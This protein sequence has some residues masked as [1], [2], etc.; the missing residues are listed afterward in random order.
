[1]I[2]YSKT[3]DGFGIAYEILG[4]GDLVHLFLPEFG[5]SLEGL[6]D[7]PA[8]TR[9][10]RFLL[11]LGRSICLDRRGLGSSDPVPHERLSRLEDYVTD[12]L[13][14]LD[15]AGAERVVITG[16]GSSGGAAMLFAAT[17]PE[18]TLRLTLANS[19]ARGTRA[20]DY[21][22]GFTAEE[23]DGLATH[24]G[25]NWGTGAITAQ[26][27]P[28]L[29]GDATLIEICARRERLAASPATAEA[30]VRAMA[31][32]DVRQVLPKIN[33]PTLVYFTGDLMHTPVEHSRYLAEHIPNAIL[34]EAPGRTFYVPDEAGGL[35]EWA[36][37]VVGGVAPVTG[38]RKLATVLFTDIVSS[39]DRA[40]ALGDES[41]AQLLEDVDS[42]VAREVEKSDGRIV[43]QTG[44]GHLAIFDGP[45]QAVRAAVAIAR[46]G[47]ALGV[48]MRCGLHV[49]ELEL[50]PNGDV[51]G[52]AVH[53]A[54][55]VMDRAGPREV[56]LSRTVAD[57]AAGAGFRFEER[58]SHELKGVPGTWQLYEV[59]S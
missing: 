21:P 35:D 13:A 18:R 38:D 40:A 16:E 4:E 9:F 14:V 48:D 59:V 1:M 27:A 51:G 46:G 29:G 11:S 6:W 32:A 24:I 39:T 43:K 30:M 3:T 12:M 28:A 47:P 41:W 33:V 36:T 50:R 15:E 49:G 17:H 37:F 44:D 23:M 52:I 58:G 57:L 31:A 10:K 19:S 54:A 22:M 5:S 8:H 20:D 25:E 56:F 7:H 26:L 2:R 45:S 42:F 34:V 53:T 55:R